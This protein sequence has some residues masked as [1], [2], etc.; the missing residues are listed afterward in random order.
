[1]SLVIEFLVIGLDSEC[2][3]IVVCQAFYPLARSPKSQPLS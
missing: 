3:G 2:G 1:V